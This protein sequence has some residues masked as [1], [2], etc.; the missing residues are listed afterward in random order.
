MTKAFLESKPHLT[1]QWCSQN[2]LGRLGMPHEL[3]GAALWLAGDGS[4]FCTG[5][6]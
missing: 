3:R 2:P 5:S 1:A 4:T 6:E